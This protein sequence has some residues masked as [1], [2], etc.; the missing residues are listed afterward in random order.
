MSLAGP[1]SNFAIALLAWIGLR[2]GLS[3]GYFAEPEYYLDNQLAVSADGAFNSAGAFMAKAL[4]VL[5]S[6]NVF[7]GV[8]NLLPLPPMDGAS[9]VIGVLP[10]DL[11]DRAS[12]AMRNSAFS[13]VG[14]LVAWW[15]FPRIVPHLRELIV[16]TLP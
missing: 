14:L 15:I 16:L 12:Q 5:V 11:A 10:R 1:A 4:S 8:F 6:L 7:L 13:L 3:T 9:A 2:V